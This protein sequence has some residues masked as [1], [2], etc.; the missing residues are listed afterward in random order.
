MAVGNGGH[1]RPRAGGYVRG[2]SVLVILGWTAVTL[3]LTFAIPSLEQVS[4]EQSVPMSPKDA[5]SV[6]AM[7]RMGAVFGES[8]SDSTAMIVLEGEQPLG[9]ATRPYYEQLIRDLRNDPR[10]VE[11]VQDLWGD[12]LTAAGAQ[13]PD[14][15][16]VYVQ[17]NLVGD[18]GTTIGQESAA[19]I[20][21]IVDRTPSPPGVQTFVTGPGALVG[22][23]QHAGERSI[24]KMTLIGAVIIFVVLMV[25]YRSVI[26]VVVLLIT[27]GIELFAARGLVAYLGHHDLVLLSTFAVNLLVALAMAAGTDYGIFFFGRYQEARQSGE[28]PET[29]L[30]TTFRGV[31]PVVLGSGLTIAGALLCLSFTRM[32]IFSTIGVPCA[33]GMLVAVVVALTLLPAVL[34]VGGRFGLFDPT[35]RIGMRRWRRI[36]TAIVRWPAPIFAATMA[37]TL[38]GLVALP[39]YRTSFDDRRY[40]PADVPANQGYAAADRHFSQARMM[41]DIL[42]IETGHDMRNPEDFIV[43]HKLAKAV[44]QVP[45]V[46]RVQGITRPEGT[47]IEHT[48]I[49]F[50]IS[51]QNAGQ[52]QMMEHMKKRVDDLLAQADLIGRQVAITKRM[53]DIQRQVTELTHN[54]IVGT[55]EMTAIMGELRDS[56]ANFDDFFRPLRNYL[57][58]E[59]HCV[60]IPICWSLRSIFDSIDGVDVLTSKMDELVIELDAMDQLLPQLLDVMPRLIANMESMHRM[61]LTMHSTMSGIF[62]VMNDSTQD[63][64]AMGMAFD[65]A[66]NDDSFYLPPEVFQ[67]PDFQKAMASFLS[68]DG[69]AARFII[70]HKG[71]PGA[72]EALARI[73]EITAAAEEALKT[74]PLRDADIYIAGSASTFKDLQEGSQWDLWIAAVSALCLIFLIMLFLT[75]SFIAALVIVGTVALSLGS[76][77]G[78]AVL[79]W[80]HI[81]GINLHWMVLPMAVIVL[82]G[83][84]S[85]YNLL[86]VS[87]MKE[88]IAAGINT[89]IIRAMG[90]TGKVVTNA[91]LVFA[92][93]MA[94][95]VFS[96][97]RIIGQVGTT[98]GIGLL[99]DTLV[100]RAFLTPSIAALL[101]RWFWWPQLVRPRPA[102]QMLRSVGPRPLVRELLLPDNR[103]P[104]TIEMAGPRV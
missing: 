9:D 55:K 70:S 65:Q 2:L 78:L 98:I 15:K 35:R 1:Q 32:P 74:T 24:L 13:S 49:P 51:M 17:V 36:G 29:A 34:A 41:P 19:A 46:S 16:A 88:E 75:R 39:G 12:R 69:K 86:L 68:P 91:G 87:R 33:V 100:V 64:T 53:Y 47:P 94:A 28:D 3:L 103:D 4:R 10:H 52:Q 6:Q 67:N 102:S 97:L 37:V 85:D 50:M 63:T 14:G 58:W 96:D 21:D 56:I 5:P 40:I 73:D 62:E 11:H 77:F 76:S 43:L 72:P 31:A 89:G 38:L 61:M 66:K 23:M 92:F 90:G 84:G 25:V 95:M 83:V 104:D 71:D 8:S 44:F 93:T 79:I 18:N 81:L 22:D 48:S 80:Q 30:S 45:G 99:F 26:T 59:P 20:R 101:G 82:L 7:T 54:S 27:V 57:Y 60:N 42:M